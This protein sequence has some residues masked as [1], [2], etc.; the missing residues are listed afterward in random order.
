MVTQRGRSSLGVLLLL[1]ASIATPQQPASSN[2]GDPL[3]RAYFGDL[4]LHTSHSLDASWASV[5]TTPEDAYRYAQGLPVSYFG[6]KVQRRAPLDFLAV[7]DH[8]EYLGVTMQILNQDPDFSETDWFQSLT[9]GDR[10][11]FERL[12]G[13]VFRGGGLLPELATEE[14]KRGNWTKVID[15]ANRF[16]QP[17]RFTT[18]VAFEWSATPGGAHNHRVVI[19]RGPRYPE[20]PFST[21]D[22]PE[23]SDLWRYADRNRE[24]EIDSLLIPH[25]SNLSNGLQFSEHGPDGQ[26]MSA[27][28]AAIKERNEGLVEVT[29]N[30]G[31]SET[32]P[33]LSA[34]DEFAS[35]EILEHLIGGE[36]AKLEGSYARQAYARGLAIAERTGVNPYRFGLVG[37]SDYHSATSATEE[38]NHTGALGDSDLPFGDNIARVL[39]GENP[40][41]RKPVTVLSASGITG[42][43]AEQNTRE[44]IFAAL[45]RKEVF[46]TSGPR[47]QV[48][49][50]A[51]NYAAGLLQR[52]N[53]LANA[54]ANGVAM[55]GT[56]TSAR[57]GNGAPRFLVSALKDPDGANLDRVQIVKV[58]RA[59]GKDHEAVFDIVWSG[60]RQRDPAT[61]RIPLVGNTVDL[62]TATYTNTIG[63]A[64]L[65]AEWVDPEFEPKTPAVYYARAIEIPTPRWPTYLAV[66]N[67]LPLPTTTPPT[68]QERAFTSPVFYVP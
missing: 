58:W 24:R 35:F 37:S 51:G 68:L 10:P 7:S 50:F 8:A 34:E 23:P 60:A 2:A 67:G 44:A 12:M 6:H 1:A 49:L 64:Q 56:L 5:R 27:D 43:W 28:Y 55:G 46:A 47:I 9:E 36:K 19:F 31:T 29:Q 21:L 22:S 18:F 54:Y 40:L 45:R 14:R 25:N 13:S 66:R 65:S 62:T 15:V 32:H 3:R 17:G 53:W 16:N 33:L 39:Q 26:P 11:G 57:L 20:L 38:D 48:R 61:G 59:G 41:L 52:P 42:V 63:G 30:K 4:H